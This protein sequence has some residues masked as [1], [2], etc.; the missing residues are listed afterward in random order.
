MDIS[1]RLQAIADM[2]PRNCIMADVGT[3]HG[4]LPVFLIIK[5]KITHAIAMDVA[6]G[7]LEHAKA[8]IRHN[9]MENQIETRLSDGVSELK[10]GEADT[11]VITGMGGP[12]IRKI[13]QEGERLWEDVEHWILSPQSEIPQTRYFLYQ[14]GFRIQNEDMVYDMGKYYVI[15]DVVR[16]DAG[17]ISEEDIWFGKDLIKQKHPVLRQYL[18]EKEQALRKLLE[19]L[20]TAHSAKA[21][22]KRK[23]IQAQYCL[24]EETRRKIL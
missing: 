19:K 17:E 11:V 2:V 7:P 20:E 18:T 14:S 16:G 24:V 22:E 3:D 9:Q 15:W 12:L 10:A 1:L 21:L 23:D 4:H 5:K 13:V 6:K 8:F